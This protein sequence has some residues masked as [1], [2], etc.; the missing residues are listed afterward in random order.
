MK[1]IVT[2]IDL[3]VHSNFSD[4]ALSPAELVSRAKAR[5]LSAIALAD[6]DSVS[7]VAEAITAGKDHGVEVIP[8]VELSVAFEAWHDIHLL[9]YA[10]DYNDGL[11]LKK[12][13][14]F[15]QSRENRNI[16]ILEKIN[17]RLGLVD[18][19]TKITINEV[20]S[21]AKDAVG[22]PHIARV[23]IKRGYV[24]SFEEA[25]RD[26]LIPCNIP[27]VHWPIG[28]AIAEIKRVGGTAI[29][30]HPTSISPDRQQLRQMIIQ[31]KYLGLEGIEVYNNMAQT[32]EMEFLRRVA[33]ELQL[34]VSAGSDFH[35]SE[36]GLEIGRGRGGIRFSDALIAPLWK[37]IMK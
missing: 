33:E 3:H 1:E 29:L 30:A 5:G 19:N 12:L 11:F 28:D 17:A 37:R 32:E 16:K 23:L 2:Y 20:L 35:G 4:G 24:T 26:F 6:H 34:F 7:G 22:R 8:S 9:G 27:K 14:E 25:F 31:L 10:I 18:E 15:K 21:H 13:R 36:E